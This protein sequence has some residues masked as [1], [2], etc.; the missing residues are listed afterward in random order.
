LRPPGGCDAPA[1]ASCGRSANRQLASTAEPDS[2]ARSVASAPAALLGGGGGS[3]PVGASQPR[4]GEHWSVPVQ[5]DPCVTVGGAGAG[6]AANGWSLW[7]SDSSLQSVSSGT[8]DICLGHPTRL[9]QSLPLPLPVKP[10]SLSPSTS[11]SSNSLAVDTAATVHAPVLNSSTSSLASS[12][13]EGGGLRDRDCHGGLDRLYFGVDDSDAGGIWRRVY[14]ADNVDLS[15]DGGWS[16]YGGLPN[17]NRVNLGLDRAFDSLA[18]ELRRVQSMADGVQRRR[19]RLRRAADEEAVAAATAREHALAMRAC[20]ERW[21]EEVESWSKRVV[22]DMNA[23]RDEEAREEVDAAARAA[24]AEEALASARAEA[25]RIGERLKQRRAQLEERL[26]TE[27]RTPDRRSG[28]AEERAA[29]V[30]AVSDAIDD[31]VHILLRGGLSGIAAQ[32]PKLLSEAA[33]DMARLVVSHCSGVDAN[34]SDASAAPAALLPPTLW[35]VSTG[36]HSTLETAAETTSNEFLDLA[37]RVEEGA[38]SVARVVELEDLLSRERAKE[39]RLEEEV[40]DGRSRS[41]QLAAELVSARRRRRDVEEEQCEFVPFAAEELEGTIE[42]VAKN[43][44]APRGVRH[45][46]ALAG[47]RLR[48]QRGAAGGGGHLGRCCSSCRDGAPWR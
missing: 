36:A 44:R 3:V 34:N 21:H 14:G 1:H 28:C 38:A 23:F 25:G 39:A 43:R 9:P 7:S 6:R 2:S 17:A 37:E 16:R 11:I 27:T 35:R 33:H 24:E 8:R 22:T 47:H 41:S 48:C 18:A 20:A 31:G 29:R 30:R 10:V 45:L 15:S 5:A 4:G 12:F 19:H 26:A 40:R 42:R 46:A 32:W 13:G